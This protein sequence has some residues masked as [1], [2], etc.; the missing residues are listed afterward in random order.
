[1]DLFSK[2]AIG[3]LPSQITLVRQDQEALK[4]RSTAMN[5]MKYPRLVSP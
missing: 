3:N 5:S 2:L 1:M 4:V